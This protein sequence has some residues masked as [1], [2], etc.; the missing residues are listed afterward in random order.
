M[1]TFRFI[2]KFLKYNTQ[3]F[4]HKILKMYK[5]NYLYIHFKIQFE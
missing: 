1:I 4:N 5:V 2:F 3:F